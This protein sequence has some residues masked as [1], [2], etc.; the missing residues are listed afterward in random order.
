[1]GPMDRIRMTEVD[2]LV[3]TSVKKNACRHVFK[4]KRVNMSQD[5]N[6][7]TVAPACTILNQSPLEVEI[8]LIYVGLLKTLVSHIPVQPM[9]KNQ[10]IVELRR[11]YSLVALDWFVMKHRTGDASQRRRNPVQ[12]HTL[13]PNNAVLS[14]NMRNKHAVM[15]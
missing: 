1:M 12:D 4:N 11:V 9:A 13:Y 14:G 2:S 10:L 8:R 7:T 5:V 15:G 3:I 6:I